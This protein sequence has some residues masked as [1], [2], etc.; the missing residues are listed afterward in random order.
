MDYIRSPSTSLRCFQLL[1][2][3]MCIAIHG[4]KPKLGSVK[5]SQEDVHGLSIL[6]TWK[7]TCLIPEKTAAPSP[8][9]PFTF[10][11]TQCLI[12]CDWV[13]GRHKVMEDI[14]FI[15]LVLS[16]HIPIT[17][18]NYSSFRCLSSLLEF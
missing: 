5:D 18:L 7:A 6:S 17:Y 2:A 3:A 14:I 11:A 15:L 8:S 16:L 9:L 10:A 13:L 12:F 4:V 1:S